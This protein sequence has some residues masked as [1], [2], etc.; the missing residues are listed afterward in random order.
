MDCS[1]AVAAS[2]EAG[3][4]AGA[5]VEVVLGD[6]VAVVADAATSAA[7]ILAQPHGA[8]FWMGPTPPSTLSLLPCAAS[9]K[10]EP[11]NGTNRFGITFMTAPYIPH[12]TKPSGK[13]NIFLSL[14]GSR[15]STPDDF[16]A[17]V[18]TLG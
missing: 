12:F 1:V 3:L 10:F 8:I 18:P 5:L 14:S 15:N 11:A 13:D 16:Y 17:T 9:R 2:A 4:E 6:A 7:S